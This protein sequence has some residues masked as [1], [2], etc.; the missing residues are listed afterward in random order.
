M[1]NFCKEACQIC[2]YKGSLKDLIDMIGDVELLETPYGKA[3]NY[4]SEDEVEPVVGGEVKE[5]TTTTSKVG[6][7]MERMVTYM[8]TEVFVDPRHESVRK[9]CKNV[10]R[11]CAIW[12][13]RGECEL[14]APYMQLWCAPI[15]RYVI[16]R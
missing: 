5:D 3:Q 14:N 10:E 7:V 16:K 9:I 15:C 13:A 2:D 4:P 12:A 6:K 1:V 8:E 11:D